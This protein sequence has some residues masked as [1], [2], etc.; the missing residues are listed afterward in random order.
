MV[1]KVADFW[2]FLAS[3]ADKSLNEIKCDLKLWKTYKLLNYISQFVSD[4][5]LLYD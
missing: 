4:P 5:T 2:N 1:S 3:C